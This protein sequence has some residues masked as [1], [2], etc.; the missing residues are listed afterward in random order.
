MA[1]ALVLVSCGAADP[2]RPNAQLTPGDWNDPPTP[3]DVLCTAGRAKLERH[4]DKSIENDVFRSYGYNPANIVRS[5]YEVD[6]LV[7]LELDGKN[8]VQNLW[9][10]SYVTQPWNAHVKDVLENTL[11]KLVCR[12]QL[13]LSEAQ[14][15]IATDWIAAYR[16][17]VRA[18]P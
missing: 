7:S 17:Y 5:N 9:P 8:T 1:I 2:I 18:M 16:K 13:D 12:H 3:L 4:V 11:H 10:Q 14:H 15:A 6:H